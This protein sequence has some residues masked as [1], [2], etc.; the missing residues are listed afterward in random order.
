VREFVLGLLLPLVGAG[1]LVYVIVKA[2]PATAHP[3]LIIAVVLF[4]VGVPLAFLS[5][6]LT[7]SPFFST[8]RE[9]Y[10]EPAD[11]EP[12]TTSV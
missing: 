9:R 5:K 7:K 2:I 8:R 11:S 3:V 12:A 1:T 6:A 10:T 4:L